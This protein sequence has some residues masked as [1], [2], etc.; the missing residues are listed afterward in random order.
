[1]IG[2]YSIT[3]DW[4]G[5]HS[6]DWGI[7]RFPEIHLS[8]PRTGIKGICHHASV[9]AFFNSLNQ[10]ITLCL[11]FF[12]KFSLL[13]VYGYFGCMLVCVPC[14]C[15]VAAE[16]RR[17]HWI[18]WDQSCRQLWAVAWVLGIDPNLLEKEPVYLTAKPSLQPVKSISK[19]YF[20]IE[21]TIRIR[22]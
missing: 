18:P 16:V 20:L 7:L 11:K 12:F 3:P 19:E 22:R 17:G 15:L 14:V 13:F 10:F 4:S 2:S 1:M 9:H 8:L 5:T 6:V 21:E